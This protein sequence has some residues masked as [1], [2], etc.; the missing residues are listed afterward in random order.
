MNT[1][2]KQRAL[3]LVMLAI[4]GTGI[5]ASVAWAQST[6][7]SDPVAEYREMFGD[8]NPA[9]LWVARGQDLWTEARG[10]RHVALA[11][12][13]DLGMGVGVVKGAYAHMPRYFKDTGKVQDL[14]T[15][16]ITCMTTEQ[17]FKRATI[18]KHK[19][20]DDNNK[21]DLEALS[22]YIVNASKGVPIDLPLNNPE[23]KH[24]YEVGKAIFYY[25]A[26]PHDFGCS[27]CHGQPGKRIRLQTLPDLATAK[28]AREAY[29]TWPAY[30]VSQGEVRTMEWR[31]HSCFRQQRLPELKFG[32]EAAIALTM[33]LA[34]NAEGGKMDAPGLKR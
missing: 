8:D 31:L 20:G 11:K 16:L 12:T 1:A 29:T 23:E 9:E 14:E 32:S 22:A 25:R 28:G 21:S 15:R 19:Y 24:A 30:R 34:K 33:F 2:N 10:P 3:W 27:T 13:C 18:L 5:A 7:P 26:G 4:A 6:T 17:G